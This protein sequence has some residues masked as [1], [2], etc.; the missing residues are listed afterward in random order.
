MI[1][2]LRV[3]VR[4]ALFGD[5]EVISLYADDFISAGVRAEEITIEDQRT[6][7]RAIPGEG[8]PCDVPAEGAYPADSGP[9]VDAEWPNEV[10]GPLYGR[11][12]ADAAL[13]PTVTERIAE[14]RQYVESEIEAINAT[15]RGGRE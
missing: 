15:L 4:N 14:L 13:M 8:T 9:I 6:T 11:G 5:G 3:T 10:E 12:P 2:R 7:T 1:P